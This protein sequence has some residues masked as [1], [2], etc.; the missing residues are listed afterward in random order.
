M[1]ITIPINT[2][3][4]EDRIEDKVNREVKQ[5]VIDFFQGA[6]DGEGNTRRSWYTSQA[7][8]MYKAEVH[9]IAKE[10]IEQH[11]QEIREQILEELVKATSK[12]KFQKELS[13]AIAD[14][15]LEKTDQ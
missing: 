7:R 9:D 5:I 1:D 13:K 4:I 15:L 11:E 14:F 2:R 10:Y 3:S 6:L 12:K 8:E